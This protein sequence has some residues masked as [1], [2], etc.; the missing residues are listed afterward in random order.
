MAIGRSRDPWD[1]DS[2]ITRQDFLDGVAITAAGLA[3][4]AAAPHLTGAEAALAASS[5]RPAPTPAGYYPPTATG[6]TGQPDSVVAQTIS[7][8]RQAEP[9][10]RRT[11][12]A[13]ARASSRA[14]S[15][16]SA[17][18]T[19][20]SSSAPGRAA[21]RRRS[22][23]G[24][25]S[26]RTR[27][28]SLLDPLPDFGGHSH[29][30][31]FHIPTPP[32]ARRRD[33]PAQRRHGQPRQHRRLEP[34]GE[35]AARHPRLLRPAGASTCSRSAASTPTTFPSI[36]RRGSRR[37]SACAR[38]CCSR[39]RTG[40]RTRSSRTR[41]ARQ[42][43]PDFLAHDAVLA[44]GAGGHRADPDRHDDGL[45]LAQA[46]PEDRPGEEGDPR[47]GSPTSSTSWTTSACPRRRRLL[48]AHVARAVRRRH[49]G[50]RRPATRGRSASPA[51]TAS[52]STTTPSRASGAR[53]RWTCSTPTRRARGRTATRRCCGCS[54]RK[55][56]PSAIPDVDGARPNQENIVKARVPTTRSSTG[57]ATTSAS[58]S[59]ARSSASSRRK[60][61]RATREA[62]T[63]V[64]GR[65]AASRVRRA[66][67]S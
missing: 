59:T 35:R 5:A 40:A 30:N 28:S 7:D 34:A 15:A 18:S 31:E 42:P 24:T 45:D 21:S 61:P 41:A 54:S 4:A 14:T 51:S 50:G 27:R 60:P 19:T 3:A 49:P 16:T 47:R 65:Q 6:I 55:L 38:C 46:R 29:R 36:R 53:R 37:R 8:R 20:A 44:G 17:R 57:R 1:P 56:I 12:R 48:P 62:S 22:A 64:A 63:Y 67:T 52:A 26:G 32:R 9:D 10:G 13:A 25:A 43:W 39:P 11:R 58:G 33:D 2:K 23:T 66:G